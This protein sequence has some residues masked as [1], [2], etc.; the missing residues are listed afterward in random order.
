MNKELFGVFGDR[1][2]FDEHTAT[3][4]Y[5]WV[6]EDE[7]ATVAVRDPALGLPGRT[8]AYAD[9]RGACLL[10]GEVLPPEGSTSPVAERT[11][12][13]YAAVGADAF[14]DL[15]GSFLAFVEYDGEA[16]LATDPAR[17]WQCFYADTPYGR[18]FGTDPKHVL[19]TVAEPTVDPRGVLEFVHLS[20]VVDE[21]TVFEELSRVPFDGYL[22]GTDTGTLDRFVYDHTGSESVDWV[23]ELADRLRR[24]TRRRAVYPGKKGLMLSAGYDSRVVAVEH[25]DLDV[26]YTLGREDHPEVDVAAD[27][28]AQYGVDHETLLL[29]DD[30]LNTDAETIEYGMGINE[31]IHIHQA[32]CLDGVDA[33]TV[34]HCLFFD[35]LFRGHFLPRNTVDVLDYSVPLQGLEPDPDVTDTLTSKFGYHSTRDKVLSECF[36]EFGTSREFVE[37]VFE[38]QLDK[39]DD[40][41]DNV[42]DSIALLGIQNQPTLSFHYHLSDNFI[43]SFIAADSELLD[44]HCRAPPEVRS[45]ETFRAALRRLDD[46]I[47]RHRP[48]NRPHDS[49]RKNQIEKF[50]R[51][52]LPFVDTFERPWPDLTEQYESASLDTKL[53]PGYPS[54]HELPVR[55]KLRV[56]DISTW[57]DG[58]FDHRSVTANDVLCPG[59]DLPIES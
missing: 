38:E 49:F 50:L 32:G 26:C 46:D 2:V 8:A 17:T 9:E 59:G 56:N 13:R 35:T 6:H 28:A 33:D 24:A 11:L 55:L 51:A 41:Y 31:S 37:S 25:P 48:P 12:D 15:N 39:W 16:V 21:R 42:Y 30:Y 43:E 58:R 4:S 5:D 3:G 52:R 19:D 27:V 53:F 47:F 45:T 36:S 54:V 34:Y 40:R 29:G 10:W 20:V 44:W 7:R 57:M 1:A 23:G 22:T 14:D 18:V